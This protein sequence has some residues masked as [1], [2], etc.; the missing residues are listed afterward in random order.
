MYG[1]LLMANQYMI[2]TAHGMQGIVNI[3]DRASG[4]AEYLLDAL[5]DKRP[6]DHFGAR[7]HLHGLPP[8][9]LL[10]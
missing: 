9:F 4:I 1:S 6:D 5:I 3:E 10:L 7:Q 8:G 2:D